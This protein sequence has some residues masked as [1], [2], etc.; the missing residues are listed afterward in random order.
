MKCLK[1]GAQMER[2]Q[3]I[4]GQFWK[5]R[6]E[7][8]IGKFLFG[9]FVNFGKPVDAWYCSSCGYVELQANTKK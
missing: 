6:P 3:L 7:T 9:T 8:A 2:G 5:R 1:C 4:H